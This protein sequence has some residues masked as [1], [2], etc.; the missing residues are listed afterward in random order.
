MPFTLAAYGGVGLAWLL[1]ANQSA[2]GRAL[3]AGGCSFLLLISAAVAIDPPYGGYGNA[4][5][6]RISIVYVML[7]V[8]LFA[9]GWSAWQLDHRRLP[10]GRRAA[11]GGAVA[12]VGLGVWLASFPAV[13]RGPDGLLDAEQ[14]KAFF[15]VLAEMQP[16][17]SFKDGWAGLLDG[18]LTMALLAVIAAR[19]RSLL[20]GYGAVACGLT[21]LLGCTHLRF[22][23]Y[24]AVL[25][26]ATLPLALTRCE[27]WP[28]RWQSAARIVVIALFFAGPYGMGIPG[29]LS[30]AA[31]STPDSVPTC[32]VRT[33]GLLL[34]PHA[35]EVVMADLNDSPELLYR[36]DILTVG[37]NYLPD[38]TSFMR[39][40]AAW[41]SAPGEQVPEAVRATRAT[42]L[43]F[44]PR[45]G[46]S[47][48]VADLPA[49]TLWDQLN[50][51]E[52]PTWLERVGADPLSG[53][54]LYRIG[55][56]RDSVVRPD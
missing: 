38:V 52:V 39:L 9:I 1:R 29:A 20:W 50:R 17:T 41:R 3:F 10:A 46:R 8:A 40:R 30:S 53:H 33:L 56:P 35:G 49:N 42:L 21:L 28:A 54:V 31:V 6:D 16:V 43:L 26:A 5:I 45:R 22:L 13:A 32:A 19:T 36:T 2:Y 12:I 11:I 23:T 51:G 4:E 14:A 18:A 55:E 24:P 15:G 37:S 47:G 27:G 7:A 44:C 48:M 34:A 25:A